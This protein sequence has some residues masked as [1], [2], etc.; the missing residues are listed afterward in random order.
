MS[1]LTS[2]WF[3]SPGIRVCF[4]GR[5]LIDWFLSNICT[6]EWNL[7][8]DRGRAFSDAV[9]ILSAKHP[10]Y[11]EHIAAYDKRWHETIPGAIS[12][13]VDIL[14]ALHK[15]GTPLYA[16]TNWNQDK[17]RETRLRF[18]FLNLFRDIVVSGDEKLIKPDAAIYQL[19]LKRNKIKAADCLFID[20]SLKNV[21]G[22]EVIGM[23]AHH[24]TTPENLSLELKALGV[25]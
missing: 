22:A 14:E 1:S 9:N 23:K 19:C 4:T 7:E 5:F 10:E 13:S 16:I 2:A 17:F 24:F 3:L 11:A 20:D 25:L 15:K 18:P 8:Q 12:G 21:K 6:H